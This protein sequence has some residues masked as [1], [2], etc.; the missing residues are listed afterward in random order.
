MLKGNGLLCNIFCKHFEENYKHTKVALNF[1][2]KQRFSQKT[3]F[4]LILVNLLYRDQI[5]NQQYC[6]EIIIC[7]TLVFGRYSGTLRYGIS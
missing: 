3:Q 7:K 4:M 6:E 2:L 1:V 5:V